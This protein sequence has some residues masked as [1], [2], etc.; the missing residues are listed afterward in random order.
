M[1]QLTKKHR[2][3]IERHL[4]RSKKR[5]GRII[6][7]H[8]KSRTT[9]VTRHEFHE[10]LNKASQPVKHEAESDSEQP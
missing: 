4:D 10:I 5:E 9:G 7:S 8:K 1:A 2:I 3:M 6:M